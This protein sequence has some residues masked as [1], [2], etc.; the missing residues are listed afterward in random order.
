MRVHC[1]RCSR[2]DW[3]DADELTLLVFAVLVFLDAAV[4]VES[5]V[6]DQECVVRDLSFICAILVN[7]REVEQCRSLSWDNASDNVNRVIF[8]VDLI[9]AVIFAVNAITNRT[10]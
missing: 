7:S 9:E 5:Y 8:F 10:D 1:V 6:S 4:R 2:D 3:H